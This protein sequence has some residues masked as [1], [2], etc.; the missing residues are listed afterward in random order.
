M[1]KGSK[2]LAKV[3]GADDKVSD[4][5]SA[6]E[7]IDS[8]I[9]WLGAGENPQLR[10]TLSFIV[11]FCIILIAVAICQRNILPLKYDHT[12]VV[13]TL[14][15]V[16]S[17]QYVELV[18]RLKSMFRRGEL[19]DEGRK[20]AE[21][22]AF[23][24]RW[25]NLFFVLTLAALAFRIVLLSLNQG[26]LYERGPEYSISWYLVRISD[27]FTVASFIEGFILRL[28]VFLVSYGKDLSE[29]TWPTVPKTTKKIRKKKATSSKSA[30]S[31]RAKK[32][33]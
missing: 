19:V 8:S 11:P 29:H 7:V 23:F 27:W 10:T 21:W 12:W 22:A 24:L 9:R 6:K 14:F 13:F 33:D 4:A 2:K 31:K 5:G 25:A 20:N 1:A 30:K 15:S 26:I 3:E 16:L 17:L 28:I 18:N 32:S